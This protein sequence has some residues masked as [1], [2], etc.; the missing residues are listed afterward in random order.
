[1]FPEEPQE[2]PLAIGMGKDTST[3]NAQEQTRDSQDL[4]VAEDAQETQ[5]GSAEDIERIYK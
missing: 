4:S 5:I 1:M 2:Q 3:E